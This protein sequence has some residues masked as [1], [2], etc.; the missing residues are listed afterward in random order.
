MVMSRQTK[1]FPGKVIKFNKSDEAVVLLL[2]KE[3]VNPDP[4]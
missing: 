4:T 3:A 2:L 1:P